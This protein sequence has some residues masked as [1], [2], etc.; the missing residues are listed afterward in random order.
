M[1]TET[2]SASWPRPKKDAA[3]DQTATVEA[4]ELLLEHARHEHDAIS[5]QIFRT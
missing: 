2:L 3:F 4:G 1:P 5:S